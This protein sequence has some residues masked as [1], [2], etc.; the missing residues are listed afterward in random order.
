MKKIYLAFLWHHHQPVYKNPRSG[1]YELPWVRLHAC[2][3]YFDTAA[4]LDE[5]PKI[6]SNFNLVPSLLAQLKE[7]SQGVA[8]DK[9]MELTLK[10]AED[11]TNDDKVFILHN[12][13][14]ANWAT[15]VNPYPRYK[16]LL[17]KRGKHTSVQDLERIHTY[18]KT[19][20]F[21]DLQVWFNLSWMDPYWREHDDLT[22][23]LY[24]K[25]QGFTEEDKQSL[26]SKQLEICGLIPEKYR[27]LQDSGQIEVS[28][29]PFYHPILPLLCDTNNAKGATPQINLPKR[30][31][32]HR[33]D[34]KIQIQKAV[35]LYKE[36]FGRE[37]R[38]MWPS[39]GSVSD[40]V[41]PLFGEAQI[42]W[43][44][45][46]EEVL[47]KTLPEYKS[48][49]Q[50]LYQPYALNILNHELNIIFRDHA[51]SDSIGFIYH[52]WNPGSAVADFM[53]RIYAIRDSIKDPDQNCLISVILDGENCWE[54]YSNDGWDFL[55]EL[56]KALSGD[57]S[58]ETVTI[59]EYLANFPPKETLKKIW[60]GSWINGNYGIWI[61]HPEDNLAWDY[62]GEARNTLSEYISKNPG[63]AE[64]ENIKSA[65]ENIFAAEGSDWNWW[66]G[67]DHSS[68]N[69]EVFDYLFRQYLI[70][71][72]EL[73]GE[74][75]PDYL[76]KSIIGINKKKTVTLEPIDFI[77]PK[78]D[79]VV[80]NY[81]EWHPA[82]YYVVG[83]SGGSIHQVE[84]VLR[85]FHYGFDK[86]N[87]HFR[88]DL[89][90]SLQ[91][92]SIEKYA[93]KILFLAPEQCEAFLNIAPNGNIKDFYLKTPSSHYNLKTVC[94]KKI[95]E[96]SIP[97]EYFKLKENDKHIE[98][99]ITI[100]KDNLEIE[101]WPY[102]YSVTIPK[103][104]KDTL[105]QNW[106]V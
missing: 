103:P 75:I 80:T 11:L 52:R 26:I 88:F 46:D 2:K 99:F 6:K 21:R 77:S 14:M 29:T 34:A 42:K 106:Y 72:Y 63:K 61:G 43:I 58:V 92:D 102:Q 1:I 64:G 19:Q 97:L 93:F 9:F 50:K 76:F 67:D 4:I 89:N 23:S 105:F 44:A 33:K 17:E 78:L 74:K 60:P 40:D 68:G 101:R 90:I 35:D 56:Y 95:I 41:I 98:F 104:T 3:D 32:Q 69:D 36:L 71:V 66:Y 53:K 81:F 70:S 83:R 28:T 20:D 48:Q 37:P 18:F 100:L 27:Q 5:F 30:R 59:N 96:L 51:L 16:Q 79:G 7:Y 54:Y 73:L 31:F 25:G 45:T 22:R 91:D 94:A 57:S 84:S 62:L 12:F 85:S 8:K 13:F 49:R 65:W 38:G 86:E 39:E 24:Q 15:M 87:L 82:G 55:R 47:F 10:P